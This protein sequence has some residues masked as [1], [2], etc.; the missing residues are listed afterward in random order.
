M[1]YAKISPAAQFVKQTG[2]FTTETVSVDNVFITAQQY[3]MGTDPVVLS[4]TYG[5]PLY[6]SQGI[7][8]VPESAFSKLV[9][10]SAA[11]LA[12]WGTDDSVVFDVVGEEEGFTVVEIIDSSIPLTT[13]T[14][15][16][17]IVTP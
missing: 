11:K 5:K 7:F 13:T 2:P 14:T 17:I 4:V 9:S 15:T 16:T 10:I 1:L 8:T 12:N 3:S 6:N